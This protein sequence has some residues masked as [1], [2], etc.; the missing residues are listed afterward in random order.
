MYDELTINECQKNDAEFTKILEEV[1]RGCPC[2]DSIEMLKTRVI[3]DGIIS[4]FKQISESGN[5]TRKA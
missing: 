4:K 5:A 3:K 1:Q 2:S